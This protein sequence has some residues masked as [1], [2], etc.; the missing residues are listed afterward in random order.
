MDAL[1]PTDPVRVG[2]YRVVARLGSGGMG[3]VYLARTP[4]GRSVAVKVVHPELARDPEFRR[5]FAREVAAARAVDGRFTAAV[6]DAGAD[7]ESP[8]LATVFV[9]GVSLAEAVA[10]HG[11]FPEAAALALARGLAAALAAV[12]AA[13]LVHRDLKPSNVLLGPDGPRVIDFGISRATEA[14]VLTRT[15]T[16]VGSPGFMSPEQAG[17]APVGTASDVFSFGA[18]LAYALTGAGPFG[19]GA[20]PALLYRV[21]HAEPELAG[22]GPAPLALIR[23]CLAKDPAERPAP[24]RILA[25][26]AAVGPAAGP[27]GSAWLPPAVA[28]TLLAQASSALE[29]DSDPS[30]PTADPSLPTADPSLPTAPPPPKAA[31]PPV[32]APAQTPALGPAEAAAPPGGAPPAGYPAGSASADRSPLPV[33]P[34]DPRP[35]GADPAPRPVAAPG[36]VPPEPTRADVRPPTPAPPDP[37]L[38]D[39]NTATAPAT[40]PP[41]TRPRRRRTALLL[42]VAAA[43][44]VAAVLGGILIHANTDPPDDSSSSSSGESTDEEDDET[45]GEGDPPADWSVDTE[46]DV[47]LPT[48]YG[49]DAADPSD[50]RKGDSYDLNLSTAWDLSATALLVLDSSDGPTAGDCLD[51]DRDSDYTTSVE[52]ADW[53]EGDLVCVR[54]DSDRLLV[55]KVDDVP[56][57]H[58]YAEGRAKVWKRS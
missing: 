12:H 14:S 8:W 35:P 5:R 44:V 49:I 23:R 28:H 32:E 7:A 52:N 51:E 19:T 3:R 40:P 45:T 15:G 20:T 43:A 31:P 26:L 38:A 46:A 33:R 56:D 11:P 55:L 16:T 53:G 27:E 4:G 48:G 47:H 36:P 24:A 42:A 2:P 29:A 34:R 6:L 17:G 37:R 1:L 18:V 57:G 10:A 54:V 9:P 13:G 41:P 22:I 30:L 39:R 25:E 58:T 21:V 50:A